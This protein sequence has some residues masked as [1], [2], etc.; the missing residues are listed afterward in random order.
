MGFFSILFYKFA[1]DFVRMVC[2]PFEDAYHET[3]SGA[4]LSLSGWGFTT[5][6]NEEKSKGTNILSLT[7][8]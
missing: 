5:V 2:L 3:Y 1:L 8:L 6:R 7:H 4:A